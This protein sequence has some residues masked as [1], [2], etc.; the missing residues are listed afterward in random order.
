MSFLKPSSSEAF[1]KVEGS[2]RDPSGFVFKKEGVIY[3]QVNQSY[4]PHF[5]HLMTSGL[6]DALIEKKWL[7][8]HVESSLD[9]KQTNEALAVIR[10]EVIPFI[11][12]PYEWC[13]SQLKDAALLTL[14][15]ALLA[16]EHGMILKD[17]SAFNV[18]FVRA[19]PL[20]ID[21]L[22][23]ELYQEGTPWIAYKQFCEHFLAPLALM[24]YR[25]ES[26]NQL[27]R[28]Y[29]DGIPLD[30]AVELL[31]K[32]ATLFNFG[33]LM[34]LKLHSLSQ[35]KLA[36]KEVDLEKKQSQLANNSIKNLLTHLRGV[37]E[38]L[39]L[40]ARGKTTWSHY[41]DEDLVGNDYFEHKKELVKNY[42][43]S[44]GSVEKIWDLGANR[45]E[46]SEV[47]STQSNQIVSWDFDVA[48]VDAHYLKLKKSEGR[49]IL[50]LV[51]DLTNPTPALGWHHRERT[52]FVERGPV[53]LVIALALIHHLAI[54]NNV[55][56]NEIA[57]F[58]RALGRALII[59][60]VPK[61]DKR[62][63]QLLL[64]RED[65]FK[66]YEKASFEAVFSKYFKI[67]KQETLKGSER[68]LY[69][70]EAK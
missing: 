67:L 4:K 14:D 59:E 61:S 45:G 42:A 26:L 53:D 31:P 56:L 1:E 40:K 23:F 58:F 6:Y 18:Q 70:M 36:G 50:P 29:L 7:V 66:D 30:L 15:M 65:I 20:F 25:K 38:K 39:N 63:R 28:V 8:P 3:R 46:F 55:P 52:S 21:T 62:V 60:F 49:E 11:S 68:E 13:F 32:K 24:V 2:F 51:L 44:L 22:S 69:L 10:P 16:L 33:L 27:L 9:L 57:A 54:G 17:A 12:Y 34:H 37:V 5:E 48:C 35:K 47:V 43:N 19:K 41:Y 64:A